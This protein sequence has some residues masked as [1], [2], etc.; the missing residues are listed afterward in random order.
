V[1]NTPDGFRFDVKAFPVLTE[2][3]L[4]VTRLPGDLRA[5]VAPLASERGRIRVDGLPD[6]VRS[7]LERRFRASLVPLVS[8]GRLGAILC[9]F[10]PWFEATRGNARKIERLAE[11]HGDLP[12]S[13]EFRHRSW[14]LPERRDRVLD[15]LRRH[16]LAFVAVDEPAGRVGG[17]PPVA[18]V[19]SP[20][21][22]VVRF[23]GRNVAGWD[24]PG[25]SVH[26][27]FD[28][29]YTPDELRPWVE[30]VRR[31]A[32]RAREVHAVFN[33]C[34]RDYAVVNAK[35]FGVLLAEPEPP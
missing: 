4:D 8:S 19:T 14:L 24:R 15:L 7:E 29:L 32:E 34:V 26:Q 28:Y 30:P 3:P 27:R 35:G 2:H 33:N 9:Q 1:H 22:A 21:L 16:D 12:L 10:P 13:I 31:L 5:E 20:R 6:A 11:R 18:E 23:H 17:V 25:A